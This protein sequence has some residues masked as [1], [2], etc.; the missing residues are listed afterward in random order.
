MMPLEENLDKESFVFL[1][2]ENDFREPAKGKE[3][4]YYTP[5]LGI[6]SGALQCIFC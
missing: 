1:I 5:H 6:R 2:I 3:I 4:A